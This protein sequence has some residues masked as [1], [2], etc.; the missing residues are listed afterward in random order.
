MTR[1]VVQAAHDDVFER[2]PPLVREIVSAQNFHDFADRP[3]LF[4]RHDFGPF[5]RKGVV[6]AH[7]QVHLGRVQKSFEPGGYTG[8][9]NRDSRGRP[10][11]SPRRSEDFERRQ[12]TVQVVERFAHAHENDVGE[13]LSFGQRP[14]LVE[15]FVR[16]K[17]VLESLSSGCTETAA[18]A[19][20]RLRRDAERRPVA[21]GDVGRFDEMVLRGT[22]EV[23]F[24]AVGRN[25]DFFG[26]GESDFVRFGEQGPVPGG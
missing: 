18:H 14:D 12:Q 13:P 23:F 17:G 3:C 9:R 24:R 4:H 6:Q 2:Y 1:R 20:A 26:S 21:V 11:E 22:I 25:T 10:A 15:D 7:G 8:G 16:R 19:A 5:V